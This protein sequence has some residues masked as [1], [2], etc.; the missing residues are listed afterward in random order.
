[1]DRDSF[2]VADAPESKPFQP[3][4]QKDHSFHALFD[5]SSQ[6]MWLLSPNG[7]LLDANQTALDFGNT[8]YEHIVGRPLTAVMGW[9]FLNQGQEWLEAAITAATEG[10]TIRYEANIKGAESEA[11]FD[12]T[13]RPTGQPPM[14]VVE[15]VDVSDR[16]RLES[17]LRHCQ[18]LE[19]VDELIAGVVHSLNDLLSPILGVSSLLRIDFPVADSHQHKLVNVLSAN[20]QRAIALTKQ[21][22]HFVKGDT[23]RHHAIEVDHL[24]LS[25]KQLIYP[26]LPPSVSMLAE[27]PA[28]IWSIAG[29]ESQLQQVLIN[30]CLNARDAMPNGGHLE[31]LVENVEI[32]KT[33]RLVDLEDSPKD[34]VVIRVSDT[35]S[36]ISP[37]VLDRIFEPFFTTK[38][39]S[40]SSGLGLSTAQDIVESHGGFI[41]VLSTANLGSQFLVFLPAL[42]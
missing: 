9:A 5:Q 19:S 41:D 32:D 34:Y 40:R 8:D 22:L 20:T 21:V 13:V 2:Q 42:R 11:I 6:L 38:S 35:G 4:T 25:V 3:H 28:G 17:H 24:L 33:D 31:L 14:L 26:A 7:M 37:Q 36:G 23:E 39:A 15:G 16:K 27:V 10:E 12:L 30:L 18:R 1:M 29:N